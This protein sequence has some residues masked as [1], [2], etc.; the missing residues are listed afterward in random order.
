[1]QVGTRQVEALRRAG[2]GRA[3]LGGGFMVQPVGMGSTFSP[4]PLL[5][6]RMTLTLLTFS[7]V[8]DCP[9]SQSPAIGDPEASPESPQ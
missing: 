4:S 9:G 8:V 3:V 7:H 1:M 6:V 5:E 2:V